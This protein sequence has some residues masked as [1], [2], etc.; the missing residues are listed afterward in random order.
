MIDGATCRRHIAFL[1][2]M[3][4]PLQIAAN[5]AWTSHPMQLL[6]KLVAQGRNLENL[7]KREMGRWRFA[8]TGV[9][10]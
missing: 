2:G 8:G 9:P 7:V 6:G 10:L 1:F 5:G 3:D 4:L